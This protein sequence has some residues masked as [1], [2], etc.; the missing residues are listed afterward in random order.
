MSANMKQYTLNPRNTP[1]P[2]DPESRSFVF[3]FPTSQF[4]K[5]EGIGF[6]LSFDGLCL[7]RIFLIP[8]QRAADRQDQVVIKNRNGEAIHMTNL[9]P[10]DNDANI[11]LRVVR[12]SSR[13]FMTYLNDQYIATKTTIRREW[14]NGVNKA[15]VEIAKNCASQVAVILTVFNKKDGRWAEDFARAMRNLQA[16]PL[17]S[18]SVGDVGAGLND[19][20][21]GKSKEAPGSPEHCYAEWIEKTEVVVAQ[22]VKLFADQRKAQEQREKT[23][24][25]GLD[26]SLLDGQR[27]QK[28]RA[29]DMTG[30]RRKD[31][32][33]S[34]AQ[35]GGGTDSRRNSKPDVNPPDSDIIKLSATVAWP[36][37]IKHVRGARLTERLREKY[38]ILMNDWIV[39][40]GDNI[41]SNAYDYLVYSHGVAWPNAIL[42]KTTKADYI[43][44]RERH[45]I[46][47][48]VLV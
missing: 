13:S 27:V 41:S 21:G 14:G 47:I 37:A 25:L 29:R 11:V 2:I 28:L 30:R 7:H 16:S 32:V 44:I 39:A 40:R 35:G 43:K 36:R 22:L 24:H 20:R 1:K 3:S 12:T 10:R 15:G 9:R 8:S 31:N 42:A 38:D 4:R 23:E 34:I 26:R 33:C 6:I 19:G 17:A 45:E 46:I 5:I 18:E 48:E